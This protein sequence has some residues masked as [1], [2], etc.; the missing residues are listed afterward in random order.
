VSNAGL[1]LPG[2][3]YL[4]TLFIEKGRLETTWQVLRRYGYDNDLC[5]SEEAL[6]VVNFA[7]GPDQVDR[8]RSLTPTRPCW[9][10]HPVRVRQIP[11][12]TCLFLYSGTQS[13]ALGHMRS[14]S[15][16][17]L[18]PTPRR[19]LCPQTTSG[20][21]R[22]PLTQ[23]INSTLSSVIRSSLLYAARLEQATKNS[24]NLWTKFDRA[25]ACCC[26]LWS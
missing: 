7:H 6:S 15:A 17:D 23:P 2:F 8:Q 21:P 16:T 1:T 25:H 10:T 3:L 9:C 4:H 14:L 18:S 22:C 13:G 11:P 19:F 5:L 20:S 12:G 24:Y 26:R